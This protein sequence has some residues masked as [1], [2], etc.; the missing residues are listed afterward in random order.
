MTQSKAHKYFNKFLGWSRHE[1]MV[2]VE[3]PEAREEFFVNPSLIPEQSRAL[4]G[5]L[6]V[7]WFLLE[8]K[9]TRCGLTPLGLFI[10][11]NQQRF[12]EK[13]AAAYERWRKTAVSAFINSPRVRRAS[14]WT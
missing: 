6:F 11:T 12:D 3:E 4:V 9:L 8:R 10:K 2:A 13:E 7:D 1:G 5:G 14:G